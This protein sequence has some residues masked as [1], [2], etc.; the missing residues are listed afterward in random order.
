MT[1]ATTG[2]RTPFV[3]TDLNGMKTLLEF[4]VDTHG[5]NRN[6]ITENFDNACAE[7]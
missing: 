5:I 2:S 4:L 3:N 1:E 6:D 7:F